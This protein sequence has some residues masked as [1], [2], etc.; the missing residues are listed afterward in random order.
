MELPLFEMLREYAGMNMDRFHMPGHKG[1]LDFLGEISKYD[2]TETP[3]TGNLYQDQGAIKKARELASAA[4]GSKETFFLVN[5]ATTG[6]LSMM[7]CSSAKKMIIAGNAHRS[8]V[9]GLILKDIEPVLLPCGIKEQISAEEIHRVLRSNPGADV[10]VTSPDYYGL[11]CDLPALCDTARD[12]DARVFLDAAHGTHFGFSK[13]L[14]PSP[15]DAGVDMW[16]N[17]AHKT[18][19]AFTQGAFL[20]VAQNSSADLRDIL[21]MLML[22][23]TS[24]PSYL[25]MAALDH[26]R[27]L[28]ISGEKQ[29]DEMVNRCNEFR[30]KIN[31][32][33]GLYCYDQK[34]LSNKGV[35]ALDPTRL[36]VDAS[37]RGISGF[38]AFNCLMEQGIMAEM[39]D[40]AS[41]V[42]IVTPFDAAE[43]LCR[44]EKALQRLP[45]GNE[46]TARM[47]MPPAAIRKMNMRQAFFERKTSV[48]LQQAA[49][50]VA[51]VPAGIYPPGVSVLLPGDLITPE[52]IEY[53]QSWQRKGALLFGV[54]SSGIPVVET[55]YA[56]SADL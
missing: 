3:F 38:R 32:C 15:K 24:S 39:A 34:I 27:A 36:T 52:I 12:H 53:L 48:L 28:L 55:F 29:W 50:K 56:P 22:L 40:D 35:A 9:S 17:S 54:D 21:Q 49:G 5:G 47:Q 44:L 13:S 7:L 25:I 31:A 1:K 4:F 20:H 10:F 14:P 46:A 8:V 43:K 51:G 26:A 41:V 2:V 18:A 11:C 19:G 37:G 45:W 33:K 6:V 23:Q 16:V 42:F 30:E